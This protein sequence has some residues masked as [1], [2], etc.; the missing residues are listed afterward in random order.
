MESPP[1]ER[2][3]YFFEMVDFRQLTARLFHRDENG[4]GL[5]TETAGDVHVCPC[6]AFHFER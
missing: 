1:P 6:N 3:T 4:L 2:G 5:K